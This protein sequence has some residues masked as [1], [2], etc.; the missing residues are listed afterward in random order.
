M[1]YCKNCNKEISALENS[2]YSGYCENCYEIL[3]GKKPKY[4]N[5]M[6]INNVVAT[7]L[8]SISIIIVIIIIAGFILSIALD[9]IKME[10]ITISIMIMA[11][12]SSVFIYGFGETIQLLQDI[13]TKI[14]K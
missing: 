1:I 7:I 6:R 13:Y 11:L 5:H 14:N 8:K 12:I 3:Q 2:I 9:E 10:S 4:D